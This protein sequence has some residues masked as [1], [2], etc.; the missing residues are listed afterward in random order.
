MESHHSLAQ[1]CFVPF[2]DL[3]LLS[4]HYLPLVFK[5]LIITMNKQKLSLRE[6]ERERAHST[7]L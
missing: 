3:N 5:L 7:A 1:L 6:R 2:I 4:S